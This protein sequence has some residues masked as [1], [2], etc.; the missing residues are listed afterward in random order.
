MLKMKRGRVCCVQPLP[1][2]ARIADARYSYGG[3]GTILLM[4]ALP[5]NLTPLA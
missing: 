3:N 5:T 2:Y 1:P 4:F